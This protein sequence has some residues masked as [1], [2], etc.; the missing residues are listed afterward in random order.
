MAE[1]TQTVEVLENEGRVPAEPETKQAHDE[2]KYTDAEVDAIIDKKFA[3]WKAEQE[4]KE[5]EAKKLASMNEKEKADYEHDKLLAELQSL[6]D[7]KTRY[8][9][10]NIARTMLSEADITLPDELLGRLVTL[11][12]EETKNAVTSFI[13]A[14]QSA[15]SEEVKKTIRQ[16]TPHLGGGVSKQTNFGASLAKGSK[17][18]G[19]LV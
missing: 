1:E 8:E 11:D 2:K 7:E 4:A 15:V 9:M 6:K 17:P 19:T 12:A 18:S 10:T 14:F 3:K 13:S 16:E 5:D